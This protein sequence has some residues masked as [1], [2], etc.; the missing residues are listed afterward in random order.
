MKTKS[1]I[2]AGLALAAAAACNKTPEETPVLNGGDAYLSVKIGYANPSTR[3]TSATPEFYYGTANENKISGNADFFFYTDGGAYFTHASQTIDGKANGVDSETADNIEW[4]GDG[5]VVLKGL[6]STATPK[7]MAVVLNGSSD[8]INNL[9][10][11]S[12]TEAQAYITDEYASSTTA[13]S[14]VLDKFTMTST[15]FDNSDV[16]SG[17]YCATLTAA[18][19]KETEA[20]AAATTNTDVAVAYVERL[21]VKA[22]LAISAAKS[23]VNSTEVYALGT[24]TEVYDGTSSASYTNPELY[25]KINGWG[26]NSTTKDSY[27]YKNIDAS[28]TSDAASLGFTWNVPANFRSYWGKS[29]NYGL[30]ATS[31]PAAYYPNMYANDASSK[32]YDAS[33]NT[34]S[35]ISYN[36]C[37]ATVS[38]NAYCRENTNTKDVLGNNNFSSAVTSV[39][40][41][42]QV[43]DKNAAPVDLVI[44]EHKYYTKDGYFTFILN[45]KA[46]DVPYVLDAAAA[47]TA[48]VKADASYLE[49]VNDGDAYIHVQFKDGTY[50]SDNAGTATDV[51]TVN[52]K[53]AKDATLAE[54]YNE[55]RMYYNIP[56]EHLRN[57]GTY[58]KSN[59]NEADYG[60]V[61]NHWYNLDVTAIA[62]IGHP[63]A[64]PD[65]PIVPSDQDTKKYFVAAKI[66]ILSWKVV[67]QS[68]EL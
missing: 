54:F 28:W 42:A 65:E 41:T 67:K 46:D 17:Y 55:G 16:N 14:S 49:I 15:S 19:F 2:L 13:G 3:G 43:V 52:A 10:G 50:F 12:I 6:T 38:E 9:K 48:Y 4:V 7:Y 40:L 61:R 25:V 66:N 5:V 29:T 23:T 32:N 68:V 35:Y 51:A 44:F 45:R 34:L 24:D 59:Y 1:L 21:A 53:W 11:K 36:D 47:T 60:V 8:L 30:T 39:L 27:T 22:S 31:T 26:L 62:N 18:M 33:K 64:V 58:A 37:S 20:E 56:I 63:V 57:S